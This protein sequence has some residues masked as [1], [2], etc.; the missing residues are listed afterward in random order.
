MNP[1][2]W[3]AGGLVAWFGDDEEELELSYFGL[4]CGPIEP[5]EM[6]S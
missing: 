2:I 1:A 4:W 6:P 3:R 5:P